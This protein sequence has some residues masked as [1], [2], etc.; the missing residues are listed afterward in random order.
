[1]R[2]YMD[3]ISSKL[4]AGCCLIEFGSGSSLK[5][6][7]LLDHL[8]DPVSYVPIDICRYQIEATARRL[9]I[10]YP[11]LE[12]LPVCAD[13]ARSFEVPQPK[14][15]PLRRVI[16]FP[17]STIGNLHPDD[18]RR[19]LRRLSDLAG[20][21]GALLIGVDICQSPEILLPAYNDSRGITA[22]FNLNLL[23]RINREAGGT[24]RLNCFAHRAV[25][26]EKHKRIEM[27]LES[28]R[29]QQVEVNGLRF[30]FSKGETI[31][32]ECSYKY[33]PEFFAT[34]AEG[35]DVNCVWTDTDRR[36][37][38]QYLTVIS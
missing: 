36:F 25:W 2:Q 37:S 21:N 31:R 17:G 1:M 22:E 3:Q 33:T 6:R 32:T 29:R 38:I 19:F 26:N 34:L 28:Q 35:F 8:A 24:F 15:K 16:Y 20:T 13:Y 11:R 23:R 18:A 27:C 30:E 7:I 4:G 12:V 14:Q 9:A 10:S 5:T